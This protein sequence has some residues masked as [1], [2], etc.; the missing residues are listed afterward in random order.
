VTGVEAWSFPIL[1][2]FK[3]GEGEKKK[4]KRES[5]EKKKNPSVLFS[6]F[7][8]KISRS[9]FAK[10]VFSSLSICGIQWKL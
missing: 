5:G 6:D 3:G 8:G 4:K 9:F 10:S 2:N 1:K 7:G